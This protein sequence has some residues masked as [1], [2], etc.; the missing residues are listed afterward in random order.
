MQPIKKQVDFISVTSNELMQ[1]FDTII[2]DISE[3]C[4]T[5]ELTPEYFIYASL[6]LTNTMCYKTVNGFLSQHDIDKVREN[7]HDLFR[8]NVINVVTNNSDIPLSSDFKVYMSKS[9]T[10]ANETKCK[11]ISSEHV[12]IS[13]LSDTN[14]KITE[15]FARFGFNDNIAR[16]ESMK[17]HKT[18]NMINDDVSE[19]KPTPTNSS[20]AIEVK[21]IGDKNVDMSSILPNILSGING[22]MS[23]SNKKGSALSNY[24]TNLNVEAR[25]GNIDTLIGRDDEINTM[26]N[27]FSRRHTNNVVIVGEAGVGKTHLV[28]GMAKQIAENTSPISLIDCNIYRLNV[29][30]LI[31]GT[32]LRGMFEERVENVI[33]ELR[34]SNG[35]ILFID[36]LHIYANDKKTEEFNLVG[37]LNDVLIDNKVKVI[38][39]TTQ[40]GYKSIFDNNKPLERKFQRINLKSPSLEDSVTILNGIKKQYEDFH[41]IT[42][43]DESIEECVRL[44]E[45]YM[46]D[47]NL[48]ASAIDIMD[49]TGAL[50][51]N[52][53]FEPYIIKEKHSEL[54]KLKERKDILLKTNNSVE[55]NEVEENIKK[56]ENEIATFYRDM[57]TDSVI[58]DVSDICKCIS[59]HTGIDV[60]RMSTSDKKSLSD[61]DKRMKEVIIG[62]DDAID[63]VS[64]AIKR[65]KV[66]LYPKNRPILSAMCIGGT[67][68]G[69]TLLAKTLAKELFG[70]EKRMVRLDMSEYSDKTSVNKLIGSSAGY[71]GYSKGGILTEAVRNNKYCVLLIDEIEKAD[72]E[73]YNLFLQIFDEGFLTD[74]IG[75]KVDF[76]NTIIILTSNVGAKRSE[77]DKP[78]G[79]LTEDDDNKKDII[80]NELKRKFP[81]EFIN[82]LDEIIYFNKLSEDTLKS[83]IGLELSK[84]ADR[85]HEIGFVAEFDNDSVIE[86]VYTH[87]DNK[88]NKYGARPVIRTI[89]NEIE[90]RLAEKLLENDYEKNTVFKIKAN[91]GILDITA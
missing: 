73:V 29:N 77:E 62:Q 24:T 87:I 75:N 82:R 32:T 59:K 15:I 21:I 84:L 65:S 7:I 78:I 26:V 53:K 30:S 25:N 83:I 70:S 63:T 10:I 20:G 68:V 86:Y 49:E 91:D 72:E 3:Q 90:N 8:N 2:N 17:L 54:F 45:R 12:L 46:S 42:Y 60:D 31:A 51:K 34:K 44:S 37:L 1:L 57:D 40:E 61:I 80:N 74:N 13:I 33:S 9:V 38:I 18:L 41:C 43:T 79:F 85:V 48:P 39:T 58:V 6:S 27:I 89:Q 67:G 66:G 35:N 64:K 23:V 47:R 11:L 81:P 28:E 50:K 71:V 16:Q 4:P 69:K 5:N 14:S 36:D 52:E 76:K 19:R 55:L 22:G 56:C 88:D